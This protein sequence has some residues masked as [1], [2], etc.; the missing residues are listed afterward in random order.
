M[1]SNKTYKITGE[2]NGGFIMRN[3][4]K[5]ESDKRKIMCLLW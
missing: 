5:L 4:W 2:K 1:V 3:G